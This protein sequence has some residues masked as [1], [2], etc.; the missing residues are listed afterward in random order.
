M[1]VEAPATGVI[2]EPCA[3]HRRADGGGDDRRLDSPGRR[4]GSAAVRSAARSARDARRHFSEEGMNVVSR[5]TFVVAV[6]AA[7]LFAASPLAAQE[8]K[9]KL[10]LY[11]SQ[12]E[13]DASQTVAAFKRAQPGVEVEV[14]RSGTTEVMGKLA[15]EFAGGPAQSRRAADRR[16][17][18][19]GGAQEGHAPASLSAKRRST[20][21]KPGPMTPTEPTS[22]RSSSPPASRSTPRR[23]SVPHRGR[24]SRSPS[25][26]GRSRCPARSIRARRRSC[27]A[28]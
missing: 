4:S 27:S 28:R 22:A 24:T 16:R 6:L 7:L 12:P 26:R 14:F 21:C 17:G 2:R 11:T 13:R 18:D 9:G 19:H 23:K 10:V 25:T 20:A 5:G 15:A 3:D 1:E 8:V